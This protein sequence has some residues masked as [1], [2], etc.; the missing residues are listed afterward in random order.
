MKKPKITVM[1]KDWDPFAE[2]RRARQRD[3]IRL[4]TGKVTAE[5]LQRENAFIRHPR[6]CKIVDPNP[7]NALL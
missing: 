3:R 6:D 5:E 4:A 7:A 1:P 2:K